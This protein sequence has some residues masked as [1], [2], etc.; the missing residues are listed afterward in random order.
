MFRLDKTSFKIQ[1]FEEADN[2][3]NYWLDKTPAERWAA[4]W[5]L[6]A[7]AFNIDYKMMFNTSNKIV[8]L[9][10]KITDNENTKYFNF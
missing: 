3:K 4:A 7:S 5:Y 9:I 2:T 8:I 10:H 1:T 6:T